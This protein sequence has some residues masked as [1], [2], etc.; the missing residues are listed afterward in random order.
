MKEQNSYFNEHPI[1]CKEGNIVHSGSHSD[2]VLN[3]TP[4]PGD[5]I[6]LFLLGSEAAL[7]IPQHRIIIDWI[8]YFI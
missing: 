4:F 3:P 1:P 2:P 6:E 8:H 7:E 5:T